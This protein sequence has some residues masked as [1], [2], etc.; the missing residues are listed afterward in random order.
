MSNYQL[1]NMKKCKR[2]Y[3]DKQQQ[4]PISKSSKTLSKSS[5]LSNP[6]YSITNLKPHFSNTSKNPQVANNPNYHPNHTN[7]TTSNKQNPRWSRRSSILHKMHNSKSKPILN[8]FKTANTN[9]TLSNH[10]KKQSKPN[11]KYFSRERLKR[12]FRDQIRPK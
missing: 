8:S 12:C 5:T 2:V 9:K 1:N 10:I 6:Q 7:H 3:R 11:K 4:K